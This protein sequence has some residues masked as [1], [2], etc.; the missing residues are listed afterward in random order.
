MDRSTCDFSVTKEKGIPVDSGVR[1]TDMFMCCVVKCSGAEQTE[2]RDP[3]AGKFVHMRHKTELLIVQFCDEYVTYND[4]PYLNITI[5]IISILIKKKTTTEYFKKST[6][7]I[8]RHVA[9]S[10]PLPAMLYPSVGGT[11]ECGFCHMPKCRLSRSWS[12]CHDDKQPATHST[13]RLY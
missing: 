7:N 4:Y 8:M 10:V 13:L 9:S 12:A 3:A 2:K 1:S 11:C 6:S 5:K